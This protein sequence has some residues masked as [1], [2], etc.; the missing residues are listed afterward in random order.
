MS[1]EYTIEELK[2]LKSKTDIKRFIET[3]EKDI[4]EQTIS[5]LDLPN[6]TDKELKEFKSAQEMKNEK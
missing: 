3:T 6:L 5:D 1:R 2:K 4:L